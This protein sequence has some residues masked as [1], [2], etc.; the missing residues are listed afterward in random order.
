[1][2]ES[3]LRVIVRKFLEDLS[4]D[5]VEE[6]VVNYI[7][8]ELHLGRSLSTILKDP[9]VRNRIDEERLGHILG[10]SEIIGAVEEELKEAFAT[11]DFRFKE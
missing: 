7:I 9:Y 1:M 11:L 4:T 5:V 2:P 3:R 8:R 6:R 10:N